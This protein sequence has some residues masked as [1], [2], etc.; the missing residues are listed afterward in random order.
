MERIE[1][2]KQLETPTDPNEA[3]LRTAQERM[4]ALLD[5]IEARRNQPNLL[6]LAIR[7]HVRRARPEETVE[8]PDT[9]E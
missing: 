7:E 3:A 5:R 4:R 9:Q 1:S 8:L 2:S 6:R